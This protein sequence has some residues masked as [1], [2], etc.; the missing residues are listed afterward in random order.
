MRNWQREALFSI[1]SLVLGLGLALSVA[2][3]LGDNPF[4]VLMVMMK[5]ALGSPT[6]IGYSLYYATPLLLTGLSVAW[7]GRAG[8]FNIG[9]EGQ[10][11]IGG[12]VMAAVGLAFPHAPSV[13]A[14]PLALVCAFFA[15]GAWGAIAGWMKAKRGAHEVL[16]TI[17]LNFIAYGIAAYVIV[18]LLKNPASQVP[19]TGVVGSGYQISQ[20]G[21][22]TSPANWALLIAL[23]SL[24]A[25]AFIFA[26]T[27]LGF[28]QRLAGGAPVAG[29]LGGVN[30]DRQTIT[31]MFYAGGFAAL[32]AAAPVL[33][34]AHKARDGFAGGA[35]FVGIAVALLGRGR[36]IGILISGLLFGILIKGS[37]DL[38]IDT[39]YVSRDLSTVIQALI[40]IAVASQPGL[41]ALADRFKRGRA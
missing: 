9:A 1:G 14:I 19:E 34:F 24:A 35:G 37:L 23:L 12:V 30:M 2:G 3:I 40:V 32:A 7:A 18:G 21:L 5:S 15:G 25:Y 4:D 28:H 41:M 29:R 16:A 27:R 39:D 8:L 6:Q 36:P 31:A 22:G 20:I 10:M 17:L 11:T 13:V 38:D 33:G 26:R